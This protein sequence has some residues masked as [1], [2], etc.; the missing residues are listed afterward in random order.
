MIPGEGKA[1]PF[2][3]DGEALPRLRPIADGI[4][5]TPEIVGP[6][7]LRIH[8]NGLER[9]QVAVDI[10]QDSD[11]HAASVA[12]GSRTLFRAGFYSYNRFAMP[13]NWER[14]T[15]SPEE[16][17]RV[18]RDIGERCAGGEVILLIGELGAGK[19][20]FTQGLAQG[21]DIDDYVHSPT[22]VMVGLY[23]GR[24]TLYHVD[25]YRIESFDEALEL[26]V[27]EQLGDDAV[28]VVEWA[29]RA[30]GA[31]GESHMLVRLTDLG[32]SS[33]K[34]V[35]EATG[36]LHEALSPSRESALPDRQA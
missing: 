27:E 23:E 35:F 22:F 9:R 19:T 11:S 34:L 7:C 21:L 3:H 17:Q 8:Q 10:R 6:S 2:S 31:F 26:G 16:T 36:P 28:C 18:A 20:C 13:T 25:L 32:G 12:R 15:S 4:S 24:R 14:I 29:D 1:A 5:Q 33:R 30:M